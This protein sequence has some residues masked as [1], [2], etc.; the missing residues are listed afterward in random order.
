M[1]ELSEVSYYVPPILYGIMHGR[2]EPDDEYPHPEVIDPKLIDRY[3]Y[4]DEDDAEDEQDDE[5]NYSS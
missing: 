4:E 5:S 2:A 1:P 3:R